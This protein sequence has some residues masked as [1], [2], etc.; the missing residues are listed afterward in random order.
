ML[1][2]GGGTRP[3]SGPGW[4][5]AGVLAATVALL[6]VP[7]TPV[8]AVGA[9]CDQ[10]HGVRVV[11]DPGPLGGDVV[12][13]CVPDG[14]GRPAAE[15]TDAAGF[16]L[17]W[18]QRYPGAFVCR[19]EDR[20]ADLDCAVTPPQDRFWGLFTADPAGEA[21]QFSTQGAASLRVPDGGAIGWRFQDSGRRVP[22]DPDPTAVAS[23]A[24]QAGSQPASA[25]SVDKGAAGASDEEAS[26]AP[27]W[28]GL[29]LLAAL[30]AT[31]LMVLAARRRA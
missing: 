10:E 3:G 27:T 24:G 6:A 9:D 21:W 25:S 22:P 18:V 26:R 31:G 14:G 17:T 28:T 11:V 16:D 20:P 13:R 2:R 15:V 1:A 23:T 4:W 12:S 7:T 5:A 8:S 30:G 29:A 19:V